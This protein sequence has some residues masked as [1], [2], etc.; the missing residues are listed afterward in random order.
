MIRQTKPCSNQEGK[1][2]ITLAFPMYKGSSYLGYKYFA[3]E[4]NEYIYVKYVVM[5][6]LN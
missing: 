3:Y 1:M 2:Q 6:D 4:N 5:S